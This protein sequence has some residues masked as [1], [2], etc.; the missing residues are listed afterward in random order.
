MAKFCTNCGNE[1][2]EN[3]AMCVKCGK[4]V[5]E[6]ISTNK[7]TSNEN[8]KKKKGLPTWAIVLIVI[9]CVI[10]IPIIIVVVLAIVGFKYVKD[11]DIDIK[12]YIEESATMKG[13]IGDTLSGDDVKITLTDT[14]IYPRIEGEAF[15]D[16]PAE[17][18]E[19]LVF[20]FNVEN[21]DDENNF[22]SIHNFTGYVDDTL[23]ASKILINNV[24]N[25][26]YLSADLTPGKKARGYVAYEVD[27]NWKQFDIHYK[28]NSFDYN[29]SMIFTVVNE[30]N[31][32]NNNNN[33]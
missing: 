20:F 18:K 24:D 9:G 28:E 3:A 10:I 5:N 12:E 14:L 29:D 26:Q 21:I 8:D 25:V 7:N 19:Y 17:G 27:T 22:V 2:P 33:A 15:T 1:L 32:Q 16:T 13:T 4:M 30:E 31:N 23:V 11:N 6:N